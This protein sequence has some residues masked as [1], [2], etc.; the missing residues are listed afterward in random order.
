MENGEEPTWAGLGRP[1]LEP[2]LDSELGISLRQ[3]CDTHKA[4]KPYAMNH[5]TST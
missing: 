2:A 4:L 1:L 5:D 3:G